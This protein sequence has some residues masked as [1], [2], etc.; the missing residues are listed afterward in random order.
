MSEKRRDSKN[1]VL[2]NNRIVIGHATSETRMH[3]ND[4]FRLL[5]PDVWESAYSKY[6]DPKGIEIHV[7]MY[8]LTLGASYFNGLYPVLQ[9]AYGPKYANAIM[10][11]AM[12][13]LFERSDV[14]Q[15]FPE[16]MRKEVLFSRS[17][18]DDSTYSTLFKENLTEEMH[19]AFRT[20]WVK[21]CIS[22]GMKKVWICI[23]GSNNDCQAKDSEYA[24]YGDNKSHSGKT[25]V[26]YIYA[27]D[28]GTGEPI[29]YTVNP[30]G[31]VDSQAFQKIVH[32]ISGYGLEIEGV[33]L[34]RGFCTFEVVKT[35]RSLELDF[36][37]MT[38][39]DTYGH[40]LM[41]EKHG[42]AIFWDPEY[43]VDGRNIYLN[44]WGM[45][46]CCIVCR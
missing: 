39:H 42:E 8:G 4:R 5:Y 33:I 43:L 23:D 14:S 34:D 44:T 28:S 11:Y 32:L 27:V 18:F 22:K 24:E 29:A 15:H 30:G 40:T 20:A 26:G 7:G 12:Y 2:T 31:V 45:M 10:D 19:D 35:L 38:P 13:S 16:R 21:R 1:R 6:N 46:M 3:P 41:L 17:P 9:D 36:V 25:I 37:I